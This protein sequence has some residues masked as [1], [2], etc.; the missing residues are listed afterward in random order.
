MATI[1]HLG[2]YGSGKS[3]GAFELAVYKELL[4]GK[5]GIVTNLAL[6]Q[7]PK[8]KGQE[9]P[10]TPG[11]GAL[12]ELIHK[13]FPNLDA[14]VLQRVRILT[15][16]EVPYFFCHR[17]DRD[18][19]FYDIPVPPP[20]EEK[21]GKRPDF[22]L[23]RDDGIVFV[24]DEFHDFFN[25][26]AWADV[27]RSVGWY[28][29]QQRKLF[30]DIHACTPQIDEVDKQMRTIGHEYRVY[31]NLGLRKVRGVVLPQTFL[32]TVYS[33]LASLKA[34]RSPLN[35]WPFTMDFDLA[36]CYDTAKGVRGIQGSTADIG[37]RPKG[38]HWSVIP[39]CF[40]LLIFGIFFLFHEG[41]KKFL[42]SMN[43]TVR[44]VENPDKKKSANFFFPSHE[45]DSMVF[46]SPPP[47]SQDVATASVSC[48]GWFVFTPR[49]VEV[50]LSDGR[51]AD[52]RL[53]QVQDL[54]FNRVKVFNQ[55][56]PVN[57]PSLI[58]T[59]SPVALTSVSSPLVQDDYS[60]HSAVS[61]TVIGQSYFNGFPRTALHANS[62]NNSL[63]SAT[64]A[65]SVS[66]SQPQA[67]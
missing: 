47:Q 8:I 30:D 1:F 23:L 14:R 56:F 38:L 13:R 61:V 5:R 18:G 34:G 54:Q 6:L 21:R 12:N 16:D 45:K 60:P 58:Y 29:N 3:Y 53:F 51:V 40:A 46:S 52:S 37:K 62:A 43:H 42:N 33:S 25:S 31:L 15:E 27:G 4:E 44:S 39:I 24:I 10:N 65:T 50:Y 64:S 32:C 59:S 20:D 48:L 67:N 22:S 7:H 26:R 63:P 9:T 66:V 49:H 36:N 19:N 35:R 28:K 2:S 17:I 11:L 55:W 57:R 41:K